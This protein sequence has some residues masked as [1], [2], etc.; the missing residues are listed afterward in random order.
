MLETA[1]II[2]FVA[3]KDAEASKAFYEGVLQLTLVSDEPFALVF[4]ANGTMLR[5]QKVDQVSPP[6]YTVLGW[7]VEDIGDVRIRLAAAGVQFERFTDLG[8]D[9]DGIMKFPGG[10]MVAWFKDPGGDLLS[11]TQQA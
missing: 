9:D 8:Q 4:D 10:A 7:M 1:A 5:V 6:P 2:A 11:I 3:T